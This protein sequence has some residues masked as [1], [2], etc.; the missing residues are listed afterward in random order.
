[1]QIRK[2]CFLIRIYQIFLSRKNNKI[3]ERKIINFLESDKLYG[4]YRNKRN[5]EI[6]KKLDSRT[7]SIKFLKIIL[8]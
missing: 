2:Y 6:T 8:I 7:N 1:M 4:Y 5:N 3:I